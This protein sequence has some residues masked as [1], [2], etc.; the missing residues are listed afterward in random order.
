MSGSLNRRS[1]L[2]KSA[3]ATTGGALALSLEEKALLAKMSEGT[4]APGAGASANYRADVS[5][6][7]V[8]TGKGEAVVFLVVISNDVGDPVRPAAGRHRRQ[9]TVPLTW[10]R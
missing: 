10:A 8:N 3:L 9:N 5:H 1:F 6:A 4:G 2:K 7:I